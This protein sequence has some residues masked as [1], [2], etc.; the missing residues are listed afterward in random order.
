L[1]KTLLSLSPILFI[2]LLTNQVFAYSPFDYDHKSSDYTVSLAEVNVLSNLSD[3]GARARVL[4]HSGGDFGFGYEAFALGTDISGEYEFYWTNNFF[5]DVMFLEIW[6]DG[7][8]GFSIG[9][10]FG[11][12]LDGT[13]GIRA[14]SGGLFFAGPVIKT[15][16]G[17]PFIALDI[18]FSSH[19]LDNPWNYY[20]CL[21]EIVVYPLGGGLRPLGI[22]FG[23]SFGEIS[24]E[25]FFCASI[26]MSFGAYTI[27]G[28]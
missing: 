12:E 28:A 13:D 1:K 14:F 17:F 19:N 24:G 10:V 18:N 2:I 4:F 5:F 26:G 3:F 27:S 16:D 7:Y 15:P 11:E 25:S 8:L 9:Y 21:S 20:H 6:Y 22:A 23:C